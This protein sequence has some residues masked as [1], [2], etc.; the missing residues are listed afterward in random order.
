MYITILNLFQL[1]ID[2]QFSMGY[3]SSA[4]DVM[5]QTRSCL[6]CLGYLHLALKIIFILSRDRRW[7]FLHCKVSKC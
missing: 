3:L 5:M 1:M 6:H 4:D 7:S 2:K